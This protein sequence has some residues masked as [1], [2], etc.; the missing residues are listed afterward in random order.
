MNMHGCIVRINK[1][2][3]G[4]LLTNTQLSSWHLTR[5]FAFSVCSHGAFPSHFST[6]R[7]KRRNKGG[8]NTSSVHVPKQSVLAI[9]GSS[10]PP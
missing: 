5:S 7:R 8:A 1:N 3:A 6:L 9:M 4:T 2:T 10:I